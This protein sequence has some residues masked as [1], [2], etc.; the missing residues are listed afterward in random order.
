MRLTTR[1][2]LECADEDCLRDFAVPW[3]RM[4]AQA[5]SVAILE[6]V[7]SVAPAMH[8]SAAIAAALEVAPGAGPITHRALRAF[9]ARYADVFAAAAVMELASPP[10]TFDGAAYHRAP[11]AV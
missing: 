4:L 5:V 3:L 1:R 7:A 8:V 2:A 9:A 10:L 11:G 6:G